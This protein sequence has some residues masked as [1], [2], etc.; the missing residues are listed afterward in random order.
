MA[1]RKKLSVADLLALKGKRKIVMT[2]AFDAFTARAAEAAGVDVIL[3]WGDTLEASKY[4]LGQVRAGA[5]NTCIG[6]GLPHPAYSSAEAAL[7]LA[8][9]VRA[10]GTDLVYCSGLVPEKFAALARQRVPSVGHVGYRPCD[11]TWFGGPRAV[12]KTAEE[13]KRVFDEVKELEAAGCIAVEMECV[14]AK[15]A[16]EI[17]KRTKM[18]VFGMGSGAETDAEFVFAEDLLGTNGGHYPRHSIK[19]ADLNGEAIKAF[20]QYRGDVLSGAYPAAKHQISIG[21][22]EFQAFLKRIEGCPEHIPPE[23]PFKPRSAKLSVADLLALKGKRKIVMTT[24]FDAFTARAAEA[25]GVDV[26]LAWGDTLE[27]SKYVLGQVRAG[28][29]NTCIGSG[30]P[31]P[32]YS[33]AE[34]ALKLAGEVRAAGTDLVYCSGLVPE[35]FAALA[36]QRVPSVGHVGY[37]PCDDTWF[38]G[39][40]AVGKT[41]EEAKRVFDEVKEL[42]AAGCIAVEMECVPAKVARE[43]TKR[44]KMLVFGM[45]SGAETDAEFVF[46]ED[47]LGTNGGHYPRH[48]IKY[49]DLNG[50]AIKAFTQYRGDVLSG[51]YPAAKHQISIGDAEFQAF[52]ELIPPL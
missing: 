22:A 13:A 21:D 10:A 8:G 9:E 6:S 47:L 35:K 16:R 36:R 39:P 50:E 20:T 43:I 18:L 7:K 29:P 32:A 12:G 30:L 2:T 52:L 38:G 48:S 34:A 40:R 1:T 42:E 33:S 15:V 11:D 51:A 3:A 27:A 5:P 37:R 44:T 24:A 23:I 17:T 19:Y 14:P 25:A 49:A 41:A 46:A 4:V 28:A 45:G 31:H 26:I